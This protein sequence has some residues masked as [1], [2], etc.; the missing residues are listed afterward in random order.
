M[1]PDETT[2]THTLV[3]HLSA[4]LRGRPC[5]VVAGPARVEIVCQPMFGVGEAAALV[6]ITVGDDDGAPPPDQP[7]LRHWLI[8]APEMPRV[9]HHHRF[10]TEWRQ[11]RIDGIDGMVDI[12]SLD[13]AL[14]LAGLYRR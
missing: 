11:T 5:R 7:G 14:P 6:V 12:D 2:L 3:E 13:I 10:G 4:M 9:R 1:T 8:M